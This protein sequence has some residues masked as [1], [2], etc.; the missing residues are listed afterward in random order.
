MGKGISV[1]SS[2]FDRYK[3]DNGFYDQLNAARSEFKLVEQFV[4]PPNSGRGFIVKKGQS[5]R[6]ISVEG[7]QVSDV[8]FW[9]ADQPG[10]EFFSPPRTIFLEGFFIKP[11]YRLWSEVPKFRPMA[12][13]I[14]D[15]VKTKDEEERWHHHFPGCHCTPEMWEMVLG[16]AGRNACHLN[17][18]EGIKPFGLKEENIRDN[19]NIFQKVRIDP[20]TWQRLF[21]PSD[22]RKDDYI[23]FYAEIDLLVA[24]SV[25]PNGDGSDNPLGQ[26]PLRPLGVEIH[27]TGVQPKEFP[28]WTDWRPT[29]KGY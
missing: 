6:V 25:C 8:A 2:N 1:K 27:D 14:E 11:F 10:L 13:C 5:F 21:A 20:E 4:V 17:F 18:L 26:N 19:I 23:E 12:T 7:P 16:K 22:S 29:W 3:Q 28:A 9:S 15:T 24:V